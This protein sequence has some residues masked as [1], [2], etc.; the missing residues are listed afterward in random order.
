MR[1]GR[2]DGPA[3]VQRS[4]LQYRGAAV[5]PRADVAAVDFGAQWQLD[6]LT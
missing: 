6:E 4:R 2:G 5:S 1:L 3:P